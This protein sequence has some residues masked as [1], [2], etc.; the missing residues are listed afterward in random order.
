MAARLLH[1]IESIRM[2]AGSPAISLVGLVR[3]LNS[4]GFEQGLLVGDGTAPTPSDGWPVEVKTNAAHGLQGVD[5]VHAH[6]LNSPVVRSAAREAVR[7][8]IPLVISPMGSVTPSAFERSGWFARLR[9]YVENRKI[10]AGCARFAVGTQVE[11][12]ALAQ[13]FGV[14]RV[15]QLPY[16][17]D[18]GYTCDGDRLSGNTSAT[19]QI[20]VLAPIHPIE[21]Y[22][23]LLKA[24]A[25]LA[26]I[27]SDWSIVIAGNAVGQWRK[28]LESAVRR[29]GGAERVRFVAAPE[30]RTRLGLLATS[31][32]LVA[33][34]LTVRS[35]ASVIEAAACGLPVVCS[36]QVA[37]LGL[38]SSLMICNPTRANLR[39][40]LKP[41]LSESPGA[42][43]RRGEALCDTA[44][45]LLDWPV[46]G[47]RYVELYRSLK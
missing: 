3:W 23:P 21:G 1:L 16:G 34:A 42:L 9:R 25:E 28:V 22:V 32:L 40:T 10:L 4:Q 6:G 11:Y 41:L 35:S 7:A 2:D 47:P 17:F 18:S 45:A 12:D 46:L 19:R 8:G 13:R 36:P 38:E 30:L 37:P 27:Y 26:P 14:Q 20:L 31:Q 44:M 29:K 43:A 39:D 33:A 15:A 5:V 24:F